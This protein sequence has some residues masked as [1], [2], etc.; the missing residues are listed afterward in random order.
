VEPIVE[1]LAVMFNVTVDIKDAIT[2]ANLDLAV[3]LL[4][5]L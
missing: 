4:T 2:A 1:N 5:L 3:L